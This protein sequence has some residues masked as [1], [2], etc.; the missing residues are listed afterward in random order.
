MPRST[1]ARSGRTKDPQGSNTPSQMPASSSKYYHPY[2]TPAEIE[3]LLEKHRGKQSVT[4]EEKV[5]QSACTFLETIGARVGFPRRTIATGQALYNRFHLFF[6][7]KGLH[8]QDVALAALYVSTKE[9]DT[10]KKP[11]ELLAAAYSIRHPE[12]AAKSKNPNGE[13]DIDTMN[14]AIVEADRQHLLA[15]ERLVLETICFNF[16]A[17][18]PFPYVI[19]FG[20]KLQASKTVTKLAW[21]ISIDSYRTFLPLIYPP[22]T[23]ALGSIFV[24][25]LLLSFEQAP[26]PRREGEVPP[27]ELA[28]SLT[29]NSQEA[30]HTKPSDLEDFAHTFLDLLIQYAQNP[31]ANTS[32]STPSSP[33]PNLPARDR[34]ANAQQPQYPYKP[35][36][37]IRLKIAMRET[38]HPPRQRKP[39][40]SSDPSALYSSEKGK[41]NEETVRF[42]FFPPGFED[43]GM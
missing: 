30:Y 2:F 21:R 15:I 27:R 41:Q 36:Q 28:E 37:L 14:P 1:D 39:L 5:R 31:S 33:S 16:T 19:K 35:D 17:R 23:I 3:Y 34:N 43:N 20:K 29:T 40:G 9:H 32:P 10:L 24:S 7:R 13:V 26:P 38:E 4:Q 12:L 25:A 6:S 42:L 8:Y 11:R 22:H 18:M